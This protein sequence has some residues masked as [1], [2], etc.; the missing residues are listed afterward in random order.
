M[1][2]LML[3]ATA[4]AGKTPLTVYVTG[5]NG[6]PLP[7]AMIRFHEEGVIRV[8]TDGGVQELAELNQR[9]GTV[10]DLALGGT[11]KFDVWAPGYGIMLM[12]TELKAGKANRARLI[13]SPY[14][15][16]TAGS[17][18]GIEAV[19]FYDR[20]RQAQLTWWTDRT[21]ANL[22]IA[23]R[24]RDATAAKARMWIESLGEAPRSD[25]N[26]L[27][28]MTAPDVTICGEE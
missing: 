14:E 10:R 9:D 7:S 2:L 19:Q 18:Q 6:A 21:E 28:R 8:V 22:L 17:P 25:A 26:R 4:L 5:A 15:F 13:L 20:W 23:N 27:C 1:Y 11:V 24:L 16:Q 3:L 12:V